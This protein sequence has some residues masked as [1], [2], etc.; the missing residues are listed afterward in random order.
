MAER[1][2]GLI[3]RV[4]MIDGS[5]R[6]VL[7]TDRRLVIVPETGSVTSFKDWWHL[8]F[9]DEGAPAAGES[10]DFRTADI[11]ALACRKNVVSISLLSVTEFKIARF[12]GGYQATIEMRSD[13]GK[14]SCEVFGISSPGALVKANKAT[15]VSPRE[16][17]RQYAL[18]CQELFKR[19]L[20]PMVSSQARW[21]S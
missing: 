21:L 2:V 12:V 13:D 4:T 9:S 16:T 5:P 7:V 15:G 11:D 10:V 3:P 1:R 19:V 17:Q 6:V 20:P 18:K 8:M 14:K